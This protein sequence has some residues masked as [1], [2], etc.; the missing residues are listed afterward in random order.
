MT[1]YVVQDQKRKNPATGELEDRFDLSP[2]QEFGPLVFLLG[3]SASPFSTPA[4]IAELQ[5]KL[6]N[7]SDRD[8]LLLTGNP[9]LIGL[10]VAV[11]ADANKGRVRLL[12]WSGSHSRYLPITA[13]GI[14]PDF[15]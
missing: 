5:L 7:F 6:Q 14:F 13:E 10:S 2:A 1:V 15:D 11:A 8:C 3:S 4:V 9:A 12:Q